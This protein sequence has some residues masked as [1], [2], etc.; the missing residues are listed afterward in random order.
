MSLNE[1]KDEGYPDTLVI[2]RKTQDELIHVIQ[3]S[4]NNIAIQIN[5]LSK[6]AEDIFGEISKEVDRLFFRVIVLQD[7]VI[8]LTSGI[9]Y[10]DE[11]GELSLRIM[12]SETFRSTAIQT[13]QVYS[14][15]QLPVKMSEM[16]DTHVLTLPM[17]SSPSCQEDTG[18]LKVS[19]DASY[20]FDLYKEKT[21]P[22]CE[23]E[24][25][26]KLKQKKHEEHPSKPASVP[27]SQRMED[28][29]SAYQVPT[30]WVSLSY[31]DQP[32]E[33][34]SFPS[35]PLHEINKFV[36]SAVGKVLSSSPHLP[37]HGA[38]EVK[39]SLPYVRYGTGRGEVMQSQ[40][41]NHLKTKVFVSPTAPDSPPELPTD[42]L[43]L[44]KVAKMETPSSSMLLP[45]Q[46]APPVLRTPAATS[47]T[48]CRPSVPGAAVPIMPPKGD[49]STPASEPFPHYELTRDDPRAPGADRGVPPPLTSSPITLQSIPTRATVTHVIGPMS[50]VQP[51]PPSISN[52]SRSSISSSPRSSLSALPNYCIPPPRYPATLMPRSST[53]RNLIPLSSISSRPQTSRSLI[54]SPRSSFSLATSRLD[55]TTLSRC[56]D[57]WPLRRS[58][59]QSQRSST[60][61]LTRHLIPPQQTPSSLNPA[62]SFNLQSL[63]SFV[64]T[65][66][67][68]PSSSALPVSPSSSAA[69]NA[70]L[71]ECP[72][73]I[74][75]FT[76]VRIA[77]T[78]AIRKAIEN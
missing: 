36:T 32:D 72:P 63:F 13:Q 55:T 71:K 45:T 22:E 26:A 73:P 17:N 53:S 69:G 16:H 60:A 59:A 57:S 11:N 24:K 28:E 23:E 50:V 42:W 12:K 52:L 18:G 77:L 25:G 34:S 66:S 40:P 74:P 67:H 9:T 20:R 27:Q 3:T 30:A 5:N 61:Q 48:A 49:F 64:Q 4:L 7:H 38:G 65:P 29:A 41:Q 10:K 37:T 1:E 75:A 51:P 35:F 21:V 56:S 15:K 76:R 68:I 6:R 47:P 31:M 39:N 2:P 70:T 43:A 54:S 14:S 58:V 62:K 46:L 33:N 78:E 19:P 8:Q 44:L